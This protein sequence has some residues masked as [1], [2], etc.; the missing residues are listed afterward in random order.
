M[1]FRE[2]TTNAGETPAIVRGVEEF[3]SPGPGG[4]VQPAGTGRFLKFH[5]KPFAS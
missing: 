1:L 3:L 2:A 4:M 5:P